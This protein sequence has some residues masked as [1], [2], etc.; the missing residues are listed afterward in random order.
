MKTFTASIPV[1]GEIEITV[2]ARNQQTAERR[3]EELVEK[4]HVEAPYNKVKGIDDVSDCV[5][6]GGLFNDE[7]TVDEVDDDE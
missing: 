3:I 2:S 6:F 5:E 7:Y 4:M 1:S